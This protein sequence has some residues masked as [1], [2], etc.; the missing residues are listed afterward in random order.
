MSSSTMHPPRALAWLVRLALLIAA[1]AIA[2]LALAPVNLGGRGGNI[3]H[4]FAFVTLGFLSRLAFP[5]WYMIVLLALLALFG[6]A[7]EVLQ[8][9]MHAG[10]DMQMVDFKID[11]AAALVGL[12]AGA[13]VNRVLGGWRAGD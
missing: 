8:G 12:I 10:R 3:D 13:L 9:T 1:V 5:R 6:G 11:V 4:A 2:Y 7:I